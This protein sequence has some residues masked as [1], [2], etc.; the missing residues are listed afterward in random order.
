M[1]GTLLMKDFWF[2]Q[3]AARHLMR[4]E[5]TRDM[6]GFVDVD[7]LSILMPLAVCGV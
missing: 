1:C 3:D 5:L 6:E 2:V 4:P 7:R